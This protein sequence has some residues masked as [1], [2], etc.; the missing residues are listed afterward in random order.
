MLE[1]VF[2]SRG[3]ATGKEAI[4]QDT[5]DGEGTSDDDSL[6]IN[7]TKTNNIVSRT[8]DTDCFVTGRHRGGSSIVKD[9]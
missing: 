8:D 2:H 6:F 7:Q 5:R 1:G 4:E 3:R 9:R